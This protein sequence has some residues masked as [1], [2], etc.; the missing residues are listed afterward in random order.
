MTLGRGAVLF[1]IRLRNLEARMDPDTPATDAA[2]ET[3]IRDQAGR[4][5]PGRTGNP[6][7]RPPGS[8][9]ALH[10][11]RALAEAGVVA[12]VMLNTGRPARA[13]ATARRPR[14]LAA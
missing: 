7:G 8:S 12:V 10:L 6:R 14:R 11:A 3:D 2:D 4:F 13:A 5:L 9:R 1:I